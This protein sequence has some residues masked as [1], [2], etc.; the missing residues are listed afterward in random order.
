ML[1]IKKKHEFYEIRF[2][3]ALPIS[4]AQRKRLL[5]QP[6]ENIR[7]VFAFAACIPFIITLQNGFGV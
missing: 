4:E 5:P 6:R 7:I 3:R 2:A 1:Q